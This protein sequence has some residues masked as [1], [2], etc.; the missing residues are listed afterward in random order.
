L[1]YFYLCFKKDNDVN[2]ESE[3]IEKK[4]EKKEI[5]TDWL[6]FDNKTEKEPERVVP[7]RSAPNS[8]ALMPSLNVEISA[9]INHPKGFTRLAP[10][11]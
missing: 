4:I 11:R 10:E 3:K 7:I 2:N 5:E 1:T 8:A 6:N 9:I